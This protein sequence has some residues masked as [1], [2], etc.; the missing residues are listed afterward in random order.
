MLGRYAELKKQLHE[1]Q[2]QAALQSAPILNELASIESE[3]HD[4][5]KLT[6]TI[7][8]HGYIAKLKPGR[9]STDH[10]GA[11]KSAFDEYS[12]Y[13]MHSLASN[14]HDIQEKHST[15]KVSVA[16]AKVTK[17][18]KIETDPFTVESDP[19]FVIEEVE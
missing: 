16:W 8:S 1:I 3:L 13:G 7:A 15:T 19:V 2:V 17:E 11:V 14:L 12:K 9:K 10:E 5:V 18:A 4:K 6:G